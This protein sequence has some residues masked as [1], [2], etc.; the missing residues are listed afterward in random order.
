MLGVSPVKQNFDDKI[1]IIFLSI[2]LNIFL[3]AQKNHLIEMVLS[4]NHN[5][6]LV[7]I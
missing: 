6:C 2:S 1:V 3:G 7:E 5:I 4:S